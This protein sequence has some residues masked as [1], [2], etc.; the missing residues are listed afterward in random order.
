MVRRHGGVWACPDEQRL[1]LFTV[2]FLKKGRGRAE[3]ADNLF[4]Y[5]VG[6]ALL[7]GMVAKKQHTKK[8]KRKKAGAGAVLA[9]K[10]KEAQSCVCYSYRLA[11]GGTS[12]EEQSAEPPTK[13]NVFVAVLKV[14]ST[15]LLPNSARL[16]I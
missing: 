13:T 11:R 12:A 2:E 3:P 1:S 6:K 4:C 5:L 14:Y 16:G 8:K 10:K 7:G 15:V 9:P